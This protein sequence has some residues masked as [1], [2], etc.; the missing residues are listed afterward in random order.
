LF[1]ASF[2]IVFPEYSSREAAAPLCGKAGSRRIVK[3]AVMPASIL[4]SGMEFL[5]WFETEVDDAEISAFHGVM[6]FLAMR[7][8]EGKTLAPKGGGCLSFSPGGRA[9]IPSDIRAVT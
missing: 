1:I 2:L 5:V 3:I 9:P 8:R 7:W 6:I 4:F